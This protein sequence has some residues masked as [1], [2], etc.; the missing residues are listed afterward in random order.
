MQSK[1]IS[2]IDEFLAETGMAP[3]YFGWCAAKNWRLVERLRA[4]GRIWPE[5]ESE[6]RAFMIAER[7]RR[8][9]E[10]AA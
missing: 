8:D 1:L 7:R 6:V 9:A 5:T 2:D 3:G 10:R 4:G